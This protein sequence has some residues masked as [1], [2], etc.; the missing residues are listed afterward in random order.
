MLTGL[1]KLGFYSLWPNGKTGK[2]YGMSANYK[3]DKTTVLVDIGSL[4]GMLKAGQI[5]PII[6]ERFPLL[7]ARQ[8]NQRLEAGKG[9][10]KIVLVSPEWESLHSSQP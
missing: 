5:K 7:E 6:T 10:G 4:F 9:S 1:L 2:S 8:A 3:E